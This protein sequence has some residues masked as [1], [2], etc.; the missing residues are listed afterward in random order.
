MKNRGIA[1]LAAAIAVGLSV[2]RVASAA[3]TY[4]VDPVHSQI[5]FRVGH[6][7]IGNVWGWFKQFE[8]TVIADA[9]NPGQ[10][11]VEFSLDPASVDSRDE[12]RDQ[13]LRGPDF[14]NVKQ[15]PR[16]TFKSR[17]VKATGRD[18]YEVSGDLTL[19]G[20]TKPLTFTLKKVG[21]GQDPWGNRRIGFSAHFTVNRLDF[22]ISYM[23]EGLGKEIEVYLDIEAVKK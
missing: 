2:P 11:S 12:K 7:G 22:G 21:E 15:A 9:A 18:T 20:V 1:T 14:F 4:Q 19:R 5:L 16:W 23:P 3:D 8:G 10:S 13:H 6:L 17:T